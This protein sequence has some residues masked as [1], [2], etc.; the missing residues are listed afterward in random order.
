MTTG[1]AKLAALVASAEYS[2]M[3]AAQIHSVI[4]AS[5]D[6]Y[7]DAASEDLLREMALFYHGDNQAN[8][9]LWDYIDNNLV[10]AGLVGSLCRLMKRVREDQLPI[11][12]G[13]SDVSTMLSSM[14]SEGI[15]TSGQKTILEDQ[16]K[17][18]STIAIE[19]GC[20]WAAVTHI[21]EALD[22]Q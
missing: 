5:Q 10:T 1:K 15:L 17:Y 20:A 11:N 12:M 18:A 13:R 6:Y 19:A 14:V 22:A 7:G 3:T 16:G 4:H 2:G 21:Q 9:L 8:D